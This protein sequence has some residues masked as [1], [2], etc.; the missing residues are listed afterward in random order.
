[1]VPASFF[2]G[3]PR[4]A[5]GG[6]VGRVPRLEPGEV[7][8]ILHRGEV[9]RTPAQ[10]AAL[11]RCENED[12]GAVIQPGAIVTVTPDQQKPNMFWALIFLDAPTPGYQAFVML[13]MCVYRSALQ[14]SGRD[15]PI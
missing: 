10:E 13:K 14:P 3:A 6:L 2:D 4:F 15:T 12:G 5:G 11:R 7:S 9:V 1:M 8:A